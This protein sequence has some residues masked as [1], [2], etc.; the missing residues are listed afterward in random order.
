MLRFSD[1][2][3]P[4]AESQAKKGDGGGVS[5]PPAVK[6]EAEGGEVGPNK[7]NF[8]YINTTDE[9]SMVVQHI[10]VMRMGKREIKPEVKV[11]PP[12]PEVTEKPEAAIEPAKEKEEE[13]EEKT[14]TDTKEETE[15][16]VEPEKEEADKEKEKEKEEEVEKVEVDKEKEAE[17]PKEEEDDEEEEQEKL[18]EDDDNKQEAKTDAEADTVVKETEETVEEKEDKEEKTE[19]KEGEAEAANEKEETTAASS[20]AVV[21]AKPQIVEVEEYLVKY[22]NFSYLH[23]EWRTEEELYKGDKRIQ[24][25]LKRFKQK[26]A[27]NTNIFENVSATDA[28]NLSRLLIFFSIIYFSRRKILSIQIS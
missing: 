14:A 27:Q 20:T 1:D 5:K 11:E 17:P 26:M 4:L 7:P 16:E 12:A 3:V 24:A 13:S 25:K 8:V 15:K 23:C 22:R 6:K 2:D 18:E 10:L 28:M 21:E 19:E 9:D